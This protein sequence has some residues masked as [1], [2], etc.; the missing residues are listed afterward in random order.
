MFDR[1]LAHLATTSLHLPADPMLLLAVLLPSVLFFTVLNNLGSSWSLLAFI[2]LLY[3]PI[4]WL[5]VLIH[6]LGHCVATKKVGSHLYIAPYFSYWY[7]CFLN[8]RQTYQARCTPAHSTHARMNEHT[9]VRHSA[10]LSAPAQM[11]WLTVSCARRLAQVFR[12][13]LTSM[14]MESM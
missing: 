9:M 13:P 3:G 2:A 7:R 12:V 6:E 4:L 11:H 5:T 10:A 8:L 14:I 1:L